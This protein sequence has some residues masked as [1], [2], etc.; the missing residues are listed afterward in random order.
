MSPNN[1]NNSN[2]NNNTR[3][4]ST[5]IAFCHEIYFPLFP[6]P[7]YTQQYNRNNRHD[8]R[9]SVPLPRVSRLGADSKLG[10]TMV[11]P[12]L[13]SAPETPAVGA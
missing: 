12:S 11:R 13:Q 7:I 10:L 5:F 3:P 8:M 4:M 2:G 6:L 9:P 1:N